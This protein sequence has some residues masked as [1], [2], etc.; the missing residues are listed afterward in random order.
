MTRRLLPYGE[1]GLLL[2]CADLTET[3]GV[4]RALQE[5]ALDDV[6]ELVPG[7][8]T[9]FLRTAQPLSRQRRRELL[10]LEPVTPDDRDTGE[11]VIGVHYDGAD[12]SAVAELLGLTTGEV[13]G[14]HTGQVWTVGFCGFAPGFGYLHGENVRL[15]VPRRAQPRTSVPAGAVGLADVWSGVYPRRGPGGWQLIGHTTENLWDLDRTP[16]ALLQ[17]GTTVRFVDQGA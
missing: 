4:L 3:I 1:Q 13:I 16:P 14:A 7:A 5:L 6:L 15:R 8:R 17:P 2:E 10:D 12:L 11:V 9:I